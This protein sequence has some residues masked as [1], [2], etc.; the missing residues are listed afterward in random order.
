M[1]TCPLGEGAARMNRI[2]MGLGGLLL[3]MDTWILGNY[4]PAPLYIISGWIHNRILFN[5][6]L[7]INK[8]T[9]SIVTHHIQSV[10]FLQWKIPHS[11]K[12]KE[13]SSQQKNPPVEF[14]W[15]F[16]LVPENSCLLSAEKAP[17]SITDCNSG[18]RWRG[19]DKFSPDCMDVPEPG[20]TVTLAL[21]QR[22]L[23]T[24]S[25]EGSWWF[26]WVR[27]LELQLFASHSSSSYLSATAL[28]KR[29]DKN[30][31]SID[32]PLITFIH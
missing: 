23:L 25:P 17:S 28:S 26:S 19:E 21:W 31:K 1:A 8:S 32:V 9:S 11:E 24:R 16:G 4:F 7:G 2:P 29:L 22:L 27:I 30:A 13:M 14:L 12:E 20:H 3:C 18:E 5:V 15:C 6:S 10:L